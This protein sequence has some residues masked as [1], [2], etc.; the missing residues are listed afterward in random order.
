VAE[1][2]AG[3]RLWIYRERRPPAAWYLQGIFG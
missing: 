3:V 2:D 1:T